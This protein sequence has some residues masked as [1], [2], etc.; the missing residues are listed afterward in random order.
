MEVADP[1]LD[2]IVVNEEVPVVVD[3]FERGG[4]ND[5]VGLDDDVLDG[6]VVT[7]C[8]VD[9]ED[10]LE[11][12]LDDVDDRE[13][14]ADRVDVVDDVCVLLGRLVIDHLGEEDGL[15]D[16]SEVRVDV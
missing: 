8:I 2:G 6:R 12:E 7:V 9:E 13:F 16:G 11:D 4:D 10:D 15:R 1:L 14:I 3:V 5:E